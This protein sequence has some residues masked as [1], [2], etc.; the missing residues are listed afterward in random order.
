MRSIPDATVQRLP[1]YLQCLEALPATRHR[2]SSDELG[3]RAGVSAAIVRKDLSRLGCLG[4]RGV[5]YSVPDL[6]TE[7]RRRL[8]LT[9]E[10]PMVIVGIGN[11]GTAL[12]S[13]EGFGAQ[14]FRVVGLFDVDPAKVGTRVDLHAVE[15][16]GDLVA[17]I[18]ERGA[19]IGVICTPAPVAQETAELLA[20]AGVVSILNFA[21]TVIRVPDDVEVRRVDFSN[22]LRVLG[23]HIH[24]RRSDEG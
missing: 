18:R 24:R 13:F 11:L 16:I 7:I 6:Q 19:L 5:G 21:P 2:I 3:V 1:L 23:Y 14:G 15:P 17:A 20:G 4:V 22:E 10:L 9:S 12:A 8:G